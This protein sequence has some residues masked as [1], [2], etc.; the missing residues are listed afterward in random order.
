[1]E[2]LG[3]CS[4]WKTW[5]KTVERVI[6]GVK[7]STAK[8]RG[9]VQFGNF[10][11]SELEI[12]MTL[13]MPCD[14]CRLIEARILSFFSFTILSNLELRDQFSSFLGLSNSD[15]SLMAFGTPPPLRPAPLL[16]PWAIRLIYL[17]RAFYAL[18]EAKQQCQ[19]NSNDRHPGTEPSITLFVIVQGFK[20]CLGWW[21]RFINC[22]AQRAYSLSPKFHVLKT[23][24]GMTSLQHTNSEQASVHLY[25]Q[26]VS[27]SCRLEPSLRLPIRTGEQKHQS[28]QCLLN[29]AWWECRAKL[30]SAYVDVDEVGTVSPLSLRHS[31]EK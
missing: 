15:W 22:V 2:T 23:P 5:A 28:L 19:S 7:W 11:W 25:R 1:M 17:Y 12:S 10:E 16:R 13:R 3:I 4:E 29:K 30:M 14:I 8:M 26:I 21:C 27:F 20:Q 24:C 31:F 9:Q 18:N 6:D